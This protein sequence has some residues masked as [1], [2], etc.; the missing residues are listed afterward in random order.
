ML[1]DFTQLRGIESLKT[2]R[3]SNGFVDW[4]EVEEVHPK[5]VSGFPADFIR[6]LLICCCC[7]AMLHE[8]N[9]LCLLNFPA[10][11]LQD[12]ACLSASCLPT[13]FLFPSKCTILGLLNVI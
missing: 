1:F 12:Y 13:Y 10:L 4:L 8:L 3:H 7:C 11:F 5:L 2:I 9:F 6:S